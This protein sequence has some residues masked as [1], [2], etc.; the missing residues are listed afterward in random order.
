MMTLRLRLT[1]IGEIMTELE[2]TYIDAF[3]DFVINEHG[4]FEN[5]ATESM[6][7]QRGNHYVEIKILN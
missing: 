5:Y 3:R 1:A 6:R 7:L 4:S 2:G